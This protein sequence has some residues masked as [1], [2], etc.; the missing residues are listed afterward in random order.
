MNENINS[1]QVNYFKVIWEFI[2]RK[3]KVILGI[4]ISVSIVIAIVVFGVI[5]D[6]YKASSSMIVDVSEIDSEYTNL[7]VA[8]QLVDTYTEFAISAKVLNEVNQALDINLTTTQMRDMISVQNTS[9]TIIIDFIV[10]SEDPLLAMQIANRI[11][12]VVQDFDKN[13]LG[14]DSISILDYARIPTIPESSNKQLYL[15]AGVI[16]SLLVSSTVVYLYNMIND[17]VETDE[18]IEKI[19]GINFLGKILDYKYSKDK[20]IINGKYQVITKLKPDSYI[21]EEYHRIRSRIDL[22]GLDKDLQVINV[23]SANPREGKTLTSL[24]LAQVYSEGKSK[25]L[26]IDL[27]LLRANVHNGYGLARGEGLTE[28]FVSDN[29]ISDY[30]TNVEPN[31]DFLQGGALV[32]VGEEV[33]VSD[34][35]KELMNQLKKGYDKI[36]IDCPPMNA[37]LYGKLVAL[38]CDGT[39]MVL[40]SRMTEIDNAKS[41]IKDFQDLNIKIIGG[42]ITNAKMQDV[43]KIEKNYYG[44]E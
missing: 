21:S 3:L 15:L 20:Q 9:G 32:N 40:G 29:P 31:L 10:T 13:F 39:L 22:V 42:V 41:I 26:I 6:K 2:K 44:V 25:T 37:V 24:N 43:R 30:I 18:Q 16:I 4:T 5:D 33:L 8:K 1:D 19:L 38:S 36:I 12:E 23:V 14:T 28:Y 7:I 17:K 34:R 35:F 11:I 27:D